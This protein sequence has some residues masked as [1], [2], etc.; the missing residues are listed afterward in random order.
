MSLSTEK[1]N[2]ARQIAA[3]VV[4]CLGA[5][6][7]PIFE[8]LNAEIKRRQAVLSDLDSALEGV[9]RRRPKRRTVRR[10]LPK[11]DGRSSITHPVDTPSRLRRHIRGD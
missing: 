1:L 9:Q 4:D 5:R 11:T 10:P 3:E 6:Y 7:L 8:C 2:Q